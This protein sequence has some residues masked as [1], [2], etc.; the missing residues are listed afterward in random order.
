MLNECNILAMGLPLRASKSGGRYSFP[1]RTR[2]EVLESG[3]AGPPSGWEASRLVEVVTRRG[4]RGV[5]RST[6]WAVLVL[7]VEGA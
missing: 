5:V 3:V 1:G 6:P 2:C 7:G 4:A